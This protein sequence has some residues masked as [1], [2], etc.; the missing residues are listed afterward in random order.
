MNTT[1][2]DATA[3]LSGEFKTDGNLEIYGKVKSVVGFCIMSGGCISVL[4]SAEV[5]GNI[6]AKSVYISGKVIG[7]ITADRVELGDTA[8]IEGNITCLRISVSG[9]AFYNGYV[10]T[11]ENLDLAEDIAYGS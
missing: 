2:I 1:I 11:V 4:D 9:G 10:K 5:E 8:E 6:V 3:N 7:D